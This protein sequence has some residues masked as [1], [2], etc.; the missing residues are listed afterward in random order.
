MMAVLL[1][2]VK[3]T[4]DTMVALKL[5]SLQP[6]LNRARVHIAK[7]AASPCTVDSGAKDGLAPAG[8]GGK[9]DGKRF[10]ETAET[11]TAETETLLSPHGH[12]GDFHHGR[13]RMDSASNA[14]DD[15]ADGGLSDSDDSDDDVLLLQFDRTGGDGDGRRTKA[16]RSMSRSWAADGAVLPT[17]LNL[18]DVGAMEAIG[19]DCGQC[20]PQAW[21]DDDDDDVSIGQAM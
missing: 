13:D 2:E 7:A 19:F 4:G 17:E 5:S 15:G 12:G 1:G 11:E 6:I 18:L 10:D 3:V 8:G 20:I 9:C 16:T 14:S 21:I